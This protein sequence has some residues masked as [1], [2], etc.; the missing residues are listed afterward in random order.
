MTDLANLK[1]GDVVTIHSRK[2]FVDCVI[3]GIRYISRGRNA[4]KREY[5]LAPIGKP[6]GKPYKFVGEKALGMP[7]HEHTRSAIEA[8]L[9]NTF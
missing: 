5:T 1:Y 6:P 3:S 9:G 4:G 2:G 8:A 7:Q